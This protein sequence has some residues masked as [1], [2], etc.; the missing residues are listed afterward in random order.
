MGGEHPFLL[1][2]VNPGLGTK[3]EASI[4]SLSRAVDMLHLGRR[5]PTYSYFFRFVDGQRQL[6]A[7]FGGNARKL[8]GSS[9]ALLTWHWP[10]IRI[11]SRWPP[12]VLPLSSTPSLP[13]GSPQLQSPVT[14]QSRLQPRLVTAP[15]IHTK[16]PSPTAGQ[17][18]SHPHPSRVSRHRLQY[19][20]CPPTCPWHENRVWGHRV[21]N[22]DLVA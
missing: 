11:R 6:K 14:Q 3:W 16:C 9:I 20:S 17:Q 2:V 18:A 22:G 13:S 12:S 4:S 5:R 1:L 15:S 8:A 19:M 21:V 10:T 7:G